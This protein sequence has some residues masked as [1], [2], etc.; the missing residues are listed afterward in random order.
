M[1]GQSSIE[2]LTLI[3]LSTLVLAGLYG[4]MVS[5]QG[6]ANDFNNRQTADLVAEKVSFQVE[7]ALVQ[8]DG[9]S[10]VFN[11]PEEIGGRSYNITVS[12]GSTIVEWGG[13]S[14]IRPALYEQRE[15]NITTRDTNVF[16]IINSGEEVVIV[17]Q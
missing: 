8:G 10:R 16:R 9:Y 6:R 5:K 2:F 13:K 11:V 4:V 12:A 14:H 3:S 7:M 15:I 17:E 1:K